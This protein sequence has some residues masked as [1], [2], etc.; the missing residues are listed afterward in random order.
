MDAYVT[1]SLLL[2]YMDCFTAV[3]KAP[4]SSGQ[5]NTLLHW[6]HVF[7]SP[8]LQTKRMHGRYF[9]PCLGILDSAHFFLHFW[10]FWL[11]L[12]IPVNL[13]FCFFVASQAYSSMVTQ[14]LENYQTLPL[15]SACRSQ[16]FTLL[17]Y[18]RRSTH[19]SKTCS[20]NQCSI[21]IF[22]KN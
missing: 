16:L 12:C 18:Q 20:V 7:T 5:I 15:F 9:V 17:Q 2:I 13:A 8:V 4:Y 19:K 1:F 6:S 3:Y 21:D 22:W 14:D 11:S 10:P